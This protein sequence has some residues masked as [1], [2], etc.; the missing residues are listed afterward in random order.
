MLK[1]TE[2]NA[3]FENDFITQNNIK[4]RYC[5]DD[6]VFYNFFFCETHRNG[7]MIASFEP[8]QTLNI[9]V[10]PKCSEKCMNYA[11]NIVS[12][13]DNDMIIENDVFSD[14]YFNQFQ[15]KLKDF[16]CNA[17][18][19]NGNLL[20]IP[21]IIIN[22]L[23]NNINE[24]YSY[25]LNN[26]ECNNDSLFENNYYYSNISDEFAKENEKNMIRVK[27]TG[28]N[29]YEMIQDNEPDYYNIFYNEHLDQGFIILSKDKLYSID[30]NVYPTLKNICGGQYHDYNENHGY[31]VYKNNK[32]ESH[33]TRNQEFYDRYCGGWE[34]EY[35][36]SSIYDICGNK[37]TTVPEGFQGMFI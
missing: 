9:T 25:S 28:L 32:L 3:L 10:F 12:D 5:T 34:L 20:D 35:Y 8:I 31:I 19:T 14:V 1:M 7:C 23:D 13:I 11:G 37:I 24:S 2:Q 6:K 16:I 33:D 15:W 22:I 21:D 29:R 17:Y 26:N 18:D 30:I 36:L 4:A 27:S